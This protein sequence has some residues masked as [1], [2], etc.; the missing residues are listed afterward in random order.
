MIAKL[1]LQ[2][3]IWIAMGELL[4]VPAGTLALAGGVGI[5]RHDCDPRHVRRIV[6]G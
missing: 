3:L 4:F 2:N 6:A 5:P 1:L